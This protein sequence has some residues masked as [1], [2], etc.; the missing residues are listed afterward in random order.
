MNTSLCV[1]LLAHAAIAARP[2]GE[3]LVPSLRVERL[4][5]ED[6]LPS[7][8]VTAITQ[9][10]RGFV[11]L[12]T[13]E[14]LARYDA[15]EFV[16]YEAGPKALPDAH[17]TALVDDHQD[18]LWI[19]TAE[20]GLARL[21]QKTG[22][23]TYFTHDP[24]RA[25]SLAGDTV[26]ALAVDGRGRVWVGLNAG[27]DVIDPKTGTIR[28][29]PVLPD[30]SPVRVQALLADATGTLWVGTYGAGLGELDP[31]TMGVELWRQ[32]AGD[33]RSLGDDVIT[34][35]REDPRGVLWIGT[36]NGGL[37]RFERG[38]KRFA[39]YRAKPGV[40]GALGDDSITA[41][42]ISAEGVVWVGTKRAGFARL[43]PKSGTFHHLHVDVWDAEALPIQQV[44][45]AFHDREGV[46]WI[47]THAGG[48][49]RLA[50]LRTRIVLYKTPVGLGGLHEDAS[51]V[52]WV[53]TANGGLYR[54]D[55]KRDELRTY[56]DG[57]ALR[58]A[59]ILEVHPSR[60]GTLWLGTTDQGLLRFDPKTERF[61][62]YPV[63]DFDDEV[64]RGVGNEAVLDLLEDAGGRLW[65]AT[66]G[67]LTVLDPRTDSYEYL[68]HDGND[69]TT[70]SS[71]LIAVLHADRQDPNV[72]WLGTA[73]GLNRLD[74]RSMTVTAWRHDPA[75]PDSLGHDY[76]VSLTEDDEGGLWI[77]TY[78]GGFQRFDRQA[79]TFHKVAGL[80]SNVIRCVQRDRDG[81][82]WVSTVRG[83]VSYDPRGDKVVTYDD[84]DGLA[85][86]E[87]AQGS[88]GQNAK[89][90]LLL[91]SLRGLN[92]LRPSELAPEV[93][94][95][96]VLLTGFNVLGEERALSRAAGADGITEVRL[97]YDEDLVTFEYAALSYVA[98][99]RQRYEYQI[100]GLRDAW[101]PMHDRTVTFTD[102]SGG[103]YVLRVRAKNHRGTWA[104]EAPAL[105][106]RVD[107]PPW[108]SA[109]A[110][111]AYI[112]VGASL[113]IVFTAVAV[114]RSRIGSLHQLDRLKTEFFSSV[115]HELRT[116]LTLILGPLES[117]AASDAIPDTQRSHV[118]VMLRNAR[119]LLHL[120]NQILDVSKFE[121]GRM[122]L[123]VGNVDLARMLNEVA[124]AF[125]PMT[126]SRRQTLTVRLEGGLGEGWLDRNKLNTVAYN[127][128]GNA[129]KFTPEEGQVT[130]AARRHGDVLHV[131][132]SDTGPGIR[133]DQIDRIFERFRQTT[134][135]AGAYGGTGIG[136]WLTKQIVELHGGKIR[137]D[138]EV[139]RGTTFAVELPIGKREGVAVSEASPASWTVTQTSRLHL[140][141]LEQPKVVAPAA[142]AEAPAIVPQRVAL[143]VDD[144]PDLLTYIAGI[145]SRE[146]RVLTARDGVD[147][148][149]VLQMQRPH[150]VVADVMMPRMSGDALCAK[151]K[152]DPELHNLPVILIS[153]RGDAQLRADSLSR[154]A[155]D[156]VDKPFHAAELL[157]R[158]HNLV[159]LREVLG[160]LEELARALKQ[161]NSDLDQFAS[162]ASHDL[163][164]PLRRI[165]RFIELLGKEI[166]KTSGD[167]SAAREYMARIEKSVEHMQLLIDSLLQYARS[168][169]KLQVG[170]VDLGQTANDAV[171]VLEVEISRTGALV[172]IGELPRV[173]ADGLL[174]RQ[175]FQNLIGNA[176]KYRRAD[177]APHIRVTA[178]QLDGGKLRQPMV[179]VTVADNG[180]GF[181]NKDAERIF[182][183]LQ[184]LH[185]DD[186]YGG[187]GIGLSICR[188]IIER[189]GGRISARGQPGV[190]ATF[191]F[192]IPRAAGAR[193]AAV[194]SELAERGEKVAATGITMHARR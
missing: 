42:T 68:F 36:E 47:G 20:G 182:G 119:R 24:E 27:L 160:Q 6:G 18:G 80:P 174:L 189:H 22:T 51:G 149:E 153:A 164:A 64:P 33:P 145:C 170:P 154:E 192:E 148:W 168:A 29:V 139:G 63:A 93:A 95:P 67:G 90:E 74:T 179:E 61:S 122:T 1:L 40:V 35:L 37:N 69:P 113:V 194:P 77:G 70:P 138:S 43:D 129:T 137:V 157:A 13:E 86:I 41:L 187:T 146:Y 17:V 115:S 4:G 144:N 73:G 175:V 118:E 81:R 163:Q 158:M 83:L 71:N 26:L 58:K 30:A 128:L 165:R 9:D 132:V 3:R 85:S 15:H 84:D 147:A 169:G 172:Q 131:S 185:R 171:A 103:S 76:V 66:A 102:L 32:R 124:E 109:W 62:R 7:G 190:G 166:R 5:V 177:V 38:G 104:A 108:L 97:A 59:W 45:A 136:L 107:P 193:A 173:E 120:V 180:L 10:T 181:D 98:P 110:Y 133:A 60:D 186:E 105:R 88:C 99:E 75:K 65:I 79:Q 114:Q 2:A 25:D 49:S 159:R 135:T 141:T 92:I 55:R 150:I 178:R 188:R 87:L 127:L 156:F 176:L 111:L 48:A 94:A 57:G 11:W 112:L 16:V 50:P 106:L 8:H 34:V 39:A 143:V 82:F 96:S 46:L 31:E 21:D 155:D 162:V 126:D 140:A 123:Q 12:G 100:Q 117:M 125:R 121:A 78:G 183:M 161:T 101:T 52:V 151:I 142:Q 23:F 116:P 89:G 191:T 28:H 53:G 19:G 184:R 72:L 130:L 54:L 167:A 91:G 134:D 152:A 44:T 14:G 56:D